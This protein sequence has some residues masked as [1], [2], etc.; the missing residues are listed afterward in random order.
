MSRP[1]VRY[2]LILALAAVSSAASAQITFRYAPSNVA[3]A[4]L[5]SNPAPDYPPMAQ[6]ARIQGN[7]ILRVAIDSAGNASPVSLITGHPMLVPAA[8]EAVRGWK[9]FPFQ[10]NRHPVSVLTVV[11]VRFGE[12]TNHDAEDRAE[13]MFQDKF[14]TALER[15]QTA[16][17]NADLQRAA[18]SLADA[19]ALLGSARSGPSRIAERWEYLMLTGSL[20][21]KQK[22]DR[23]A[24]QQYTQALALQKGSKESPE[25]AASLSALGELYYQTGRSQLAEE[26]LERALSIYQKKYKKTAKSPADRTSY[27]HSI[28]ETAWM[29]SKIAATEKQPEEAVRQC[30]AVLEVK[31][32]LDVNDPNVTECERFIAGLGTAK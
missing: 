26:S 3:A 2:I 4:H 25:A 10:I 14:W 24:E 17:G 16:L 8:M 7:V 27:A 5:K 23:E 13:V 28:A 31:N 18:Q 15:A 20:Y 32:G 12:P 9:Y 30:R 22:Q 6:A 21:R 1:M 11:V 19:E 29:L